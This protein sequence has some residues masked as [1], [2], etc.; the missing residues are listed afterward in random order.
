MAQP[1]IQQVRAAHIL[2]PVEQTD[3][4]TNAVQLVNEPCQICG[5]TTIRTG[6]PGALCPGCR[7]FV[8]AFNHRICRII[9][10]AGG[11]MS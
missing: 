8:T 4:P 10:L 3:K 6:L 5:V 7:R 1:T 11:G 9:D 2:P